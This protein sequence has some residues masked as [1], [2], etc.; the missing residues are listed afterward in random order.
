MRLGGSGE[1]DGGGSPEPRGEA[2]D[3]DVDLHVPAQRAETAGRHGAAVVAVIAAGGALGALARHAMEVWLPAGGGAG[4]TGGAWAG[5]PGGIFLVNLLG[6]ASIGVLMVLIGEGDRER[7]THALVRPFLGA[8]VLGGFTTF[9]TYVAGVALL[10]EAGRYGVAVAYLGGTLLGALIA[11]WA[12]AAA[13]R[14][15]LARRRGEG[16]GGRRRTDA[17]GGAR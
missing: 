4:G 9:S 14:A 3:P 12:G 10:L 7:R 1:G 11:V 16:P 5:F 8:G 2:V 6:C 17:G 13:T 15:A